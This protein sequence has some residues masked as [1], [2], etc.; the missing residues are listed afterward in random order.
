M[1]FF[2]LKINYFTH[3]I[4]KKKRH[5]ANRIRKFVEFKIKYSVPTMQIIRWLK[6]NYF[7]PPTKKIVNFLQM[8]EKRD[9]GAILKLP[10]IFCKF[11]GNIHLGHS[12]ARKAIRQCGEIE[13]MD[14]GS[15]TTSEKILSAVEKMPERSE[16][17]EEVDYEQMLAIKKQPK[18][19][20][21]SLKISF[22]FSKIIFQT[23][24]IDNR[25]DLKDWREFVCME[26]KKLEIDLGSCGSEVADLVVDE[27][28]FAPSQQG[29]Q[30][31]IIEA[32]IGFAKKLIE[33]SM[34]VFESQKA[35]DL[36]DESL[37]KVLV[38]M[39]I[40]NAIRKEHTLDFLSNKG[41]G[42]QIVNYTVKAETKLFK[43]DHF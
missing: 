19:W 30:D 25:N 9:T 10:E 35:N 12:D 16:E 24:E 43:D 29:A 2:C 15:F 4:E 34:Q 7:Q 40:Y 42:Q 1:F 17:E 41:L 28:E 38:P 36:E 26:G 37:V 11:C 32:T 5:R 23:R 39:H 8:R 31:M 21:F 27:A 18:H 22:C 13:M 3:F 6:T 33:K 14:F 20:P